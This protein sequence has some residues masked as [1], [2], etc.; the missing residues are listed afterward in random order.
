MAAKSVGF[1]GTGI[2]GKPMARNLLKAGYA[3]TVH[4][5]TKSKAR[6]LL[7]EGGR[8]GGHCHRCPGLRGKG[9]P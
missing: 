6:D 3:V 4:N 1:I 9:R 8:L 5:R 2:M 7:S